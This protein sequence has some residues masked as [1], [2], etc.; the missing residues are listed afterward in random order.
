MVSPEE[1]LQRAREARQTLEATANTTD[2]IR[3]LL[4][5][6]SFREYVEPE[7]LDSDNIAA[8]ELNEQLAV[9]SERINQVGQDIEK[10]GRTEPSEPEEE[11]VDYEHDSELESTLG[12]EP[13]AAASAPSAPCETKDYPQ[14]LKLTSKRY[15]TKS[16]N[17]LW[18]VKPEQIEQMGYCKCVQ[19]VR[20][21]SGKSCRVTADKI[22]T[23][24][25]KGSPS[26]D[27]CFDFMLLTE[28]QNDLALATDS[29][30]KPWHYVR[31]TWGYGR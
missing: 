18:S 17:Y 6:E 30:H 5:D 20:D 2:Q 16:F 15:D 14:I 26:S 12:D 10:I 9:L 1:L 3:R 4:M 31:I 21:D 11:P 27:G 13:Q 22:L 7:I 24:M 28:R 8:S 19:F 23:A 25:E 29:K